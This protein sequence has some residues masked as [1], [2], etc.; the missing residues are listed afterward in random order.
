MRSI[1]LIVKLSIAPSMREDLRSET[2]PNYAPR[3]GL[4]NEQSARWGR[5]RWATAEARPRAYKRPM[6]DLARPGAVRP[7]RLAVRAALSLRRRLLALADAVVP[8][9]LAL[10]EQA[11]G[12]GRTQLLRAASQLRLADRL[13]AGP[14]T[15]E[16]LAR[17]VDADPD[18]VHRVLRALASGGVFALRPD[19]RFENNHLSRA[20]RA[21]APGSMAPLAE[22]LGSRSNAAAWADL[23]AT[24]ATGQSAFRRVHGM[25]V[26]EWFER[27]D[28]ERR[29]FADAMGRVTEL[30]ATAIAE[31]YAFGELDL[32]CDVA[33]GHG[34][35]LAE[36]LR[37]HPRPRGLLLDAPATVAEA[38]PFLERRGVAARV[39][40]RAGSFFD[41][42]PEGCD[43]YLLKDVLHDWDDAACLRILGSCRRG[44]RRGARLLVAEVLL[45]R[46]A[47]ASPAAL[48]DVQ[49]MVVCEQ[50]RQ[51]SAAEL[52]AL[53]GRAGFRP[54]RVLG[55]AGALSLVEAV[56]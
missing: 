32:V 53:L 11:M 49:M 54:A 9:Q 51:R 6:L 2:G 50:G 43:V 30:D 40:C 35:L 38:P 46:N 1:S 37:R 5:A 20:L 44:A 12:V 13:E 56:A 15:A 22:Y 8:P 23:D 34:T 21:D 31:G 25:T 27:H 45:E 19:G 26:W 47:P 3:R 42:V 55:M 24:V 39:T 4:S 41:G 29:T 36:I 48:A 10:F 33:G 52:Q 18:A 16:D 14:R 7:P 17:E 28:A